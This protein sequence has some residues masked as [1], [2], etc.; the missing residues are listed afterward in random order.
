VLT[1][2]WDSKNFTDDDWH[3]TMREVGWIH[4]SIDSMEVLTS[5]KGRAVV[6]WVG[7]W[8]KATKDNHTVSDVLNNSV[9]EQ[10]RISP[11]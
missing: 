1:A 9:L 5:S 2:V 3:D 4:N 11:G 7:S 8:R 6:R 10:W